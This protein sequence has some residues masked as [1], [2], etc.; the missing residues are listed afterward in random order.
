[1]VGEILLPFPLMLKLLRL[2]FN[3]LLVMCELWL[4]T[5]WLLLIWFSLANDGVTDVAG[6]PWP[7]SSVKIWV[8][9]LGSALMRSMLVLNLLTIVS[10]LWRLNGRGG[11]NVR[12]NQ[13]WNANKLFPS[14][15]WGFRNIKHWKF[16]QIFSNLS[17]PYLHNIHRPSSWQ[18][19]GESSEEQQRDQAVVIEITTS[20]KQKI[21]KP[22]IK[23][24]R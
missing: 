16:E 9:K 12:F 23:S 21:G 1:M 8:K 14:L 6:M 13:V 17:C 10:D 15:R 22:S 11:K 7:F 24:T 20:R 19:H 2:S 3:K 4:T 5:I 18:W